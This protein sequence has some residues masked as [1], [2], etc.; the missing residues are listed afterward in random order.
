MDGRPP[1]FV[2]IRVDSAQYNSCMYP[3]RFLRTP[4]IGSLALLWLLATGMAVA[5]EPR[6]DLEVAMDKDFSPTD[7]RAWNEMLGGLGLANVRLRGIKPNDQPEIRPLGEGQTASYR[8]T[9]ILT[10]DR[11]V[12]VKGKFGI[13]D[14]GGLERYFAKLKESGVE[15]V[16]E[17]P[18]AFGLTSAQLVA[19]HEALAVPVNFQ[20]SGE[21]PQ[22]AAK[23]ISQ[24]LSLKFT[25]DSAGQRALSAD[26]PI[27]DEL[28]GLSAGTALVAILRPLGLV[29]VPERSGGETRLRIADSRAASEH[30]PVGWPPQGNPHETLP[31]LFNKLNVEVDSTPL[32]EALPTIGARLKVPIL[33]DHNSLARAEIDLSTRVDLPKT[34]TYYDKIVSRLLFQANLKHELR[35]DEAG[36]PLLWITTLRQ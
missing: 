20:T 25:T 11:L 16:T 2:G 26:E 23:R 1:F 31:Q 15:G 30:W 5:A 27:L 34:N 24:S 17:K 12:L 3:T 22:T 29:L 14:R 4:L 28:Q 18:A 9:G 7:A 36:R 6:I 19:L 10:G 32:A 21:R 13:G 35:V 8:V 33:I